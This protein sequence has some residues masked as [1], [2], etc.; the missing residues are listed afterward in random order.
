MTSHLKGIGGVLRAKPS[1][2]VVHEIPLYQPSGSGSHLYI[3][4]TKELETTEEVANQ[5]AKLLCISQRD[6]GFAGMKDKHAITTQTFSVPV[7]NDQ[8]PEII[9]EKLN[10][11]TAK[12]NWSKLHVN[13]LKTGH[14][15][16]NTFSILI[17][18]LENE[19]DS[20]DR[21][22]NIVKSI[23]ETGLPNFFGEQ[24]FGVDNDNAERGLAIIRGNL[25]VRDKW[26]RRFLL[27]SLQSNLCNKYLATRLERKLFRIIPGDICKKHDTGG[28][29]ASENVVEEQQRYEKKEISFTAPIY[30]PDMW[31][32]DCNAADLENEILEKSGIKMEELDKAGIL[33]TRRLG[34]LLVS[35]L[36]IEKCEEGILTSFSLP[37]GAFAT[38]VLREIMKNEK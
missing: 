2:F 35:D 38:T 4:I 31:F 8:S 32:A 5:I 26:L 21:A 20:F 3:N 17:S 18:N 19:E 36:K 7:G 25:S 34:R 27:S 9:I 12:I 11:I 22:N 30:G 16:G 37:K 23:C 29:F 1:H 24:R 15:I 14:L 10:S 6:V 28:L 33:G 13:K